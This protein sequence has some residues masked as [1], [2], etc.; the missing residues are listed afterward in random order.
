LNL[1]INWGFFFFLKTELSENE[2]DKLKFA[3]ES[4]RLRVELDKKAKELGNLKESKKE[5]FESMKPIKVQLLEKGLELEKVEERFRFYEKNVDEFNF[6]DG[7]SLW[8][9]IEK[10]NLNNNFLE[11]KE[12]IQNMNEVRN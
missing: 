6:V 8:N 3:E 1:I 4:E 10:E 12:K 7:N 5:L 9:N 11:K 2:N